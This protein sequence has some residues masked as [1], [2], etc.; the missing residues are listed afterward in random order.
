MQRRV[1]MSRQVR[2]RGYNNRDYEEEDMRSYTPRKVS[3]GQDYDKFNNGYNVADR[4]SSPGRNRVRGN[5][6]TP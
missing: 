4:S 2:A 3:Y 1:P 5:I 6:E